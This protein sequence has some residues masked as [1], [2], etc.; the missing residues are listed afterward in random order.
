MSGAFAELALLSLRMMTALI[1][2]AAIAAFAS[3][4]SVRRKTRDFCAGLME[5]FAIAGTVSA[6]AAIGFMWVAR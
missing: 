1:V 3:V 6:I 2:V 4:S 5:F